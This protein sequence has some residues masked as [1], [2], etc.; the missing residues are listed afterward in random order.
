MWYT[1]KGRVGVVSLSK[2]DGAGE[3]D[4]A[5]KQ[6]ED[7]QAQLAHAGPQC[8]TEDLEAL[9]V[10]RQLEDPEHPH[11]PDDSDDGQGCGRRGI[12]VLGQLCSQSDKIGQ[13]GTEI[14]D[15]HDILK[16]VHLAG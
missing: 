3:E 14:D 11:Q 5:N 9:R 12:I 16:E 6:E 7:K 2:V 4:D 15:V 13:D 10:T 8:L 1:D